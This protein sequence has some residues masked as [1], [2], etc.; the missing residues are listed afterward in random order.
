MKNID[1]L[2]EKYYNTYKGDY[3]TDVELNDAKKQNF[4]CKQF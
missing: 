4:G 1:D 2:Y 3:D